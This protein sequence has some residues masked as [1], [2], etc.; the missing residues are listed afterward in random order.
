MFK[1]FLKGLVFGAGFSVA[2]IV[3]YTIWCSLGLRTQVF[4]RDGF[5][6]DDSKDGGQKVLIPPALVEKPKYLGS[7]GFYFGEFEHSSSKVLASGEGEIVGSI[8]VDDVPKEGVRVRLALNGTVYSEWAKSGVDGRYTVRVP[9][10][11]Y[12]IDGYELERE[13]A[14]KYLAGKIAHPRMPRGGG[15]FSVGKNKSGIGLNLDF[16]D[17]VEFTEPT[18]EVSLSEEIV[19]KWEPYPGASSYVVQVYE[20]EDAHGLSF[21]GVLFDWNELP[22]VTEPFMDLKEKQVALKAGSFYT[23][24]IRAKDERGRTIS[25]TPTTFHERGFKV[26]D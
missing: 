8:S 2:V 10:G 20:R 26:T 24:L 17:P 22:E 11:E 25:E 5:V 14:N 15:P 1:Q 23:L 21:S 7:S 6:F 9:Y 13:S 19:A 18:G 16:V 4:G 12:R 3:V